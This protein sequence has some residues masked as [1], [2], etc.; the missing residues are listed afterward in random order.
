MRSHHPSIAGRKA[1]PVNAFHFK[2]KSVS[3][4]VGHGKK[5]LQCV[6]LH[7]RKKKRAPAAHIKY[8]DMLMETTSLTQEAL[9]T[10]SMNVSLLFD[11]LTNITFRRGLGPGLRP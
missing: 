2:N 8:R 4:Q 5:R 6:R 10:T 1:Q 9:Y 3:T 7:R 11:S